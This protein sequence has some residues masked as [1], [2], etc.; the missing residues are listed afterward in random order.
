M[1]SSFS[2]EIPELLN[3]ALAE[4]Q[5]RNPTSDIMESS[6]PFDKYAAIPLH[7]YDCYCI[8]RRG[9]AR[10]VQKLKILE[11]GR[12]MLGRHKIEINGETT[13]TNSLTTF[14]RKTLKMTDKLA[15]DRSTFIIQNNV[16]VRL[17][18]IRKRIWLPPLSDDF[19]EM[20][21][22]PDLIP[23]LPQIV[24]KDKICPVTKSKTKRDNYEGFL[25]FYLRK[26]YVSK[27]NSYENRRK[28]ILN[29]LETCN[30]L[31]EEIEE[32]IQAG[33][34]LLLLKAKERV[35]KRKRDVP[36]SPMQQQQDHGLEEISNTDSPTV[37]TSEISFLSQNYFD[38][39]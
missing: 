39:G 13:Y 14:K 26:L 29:C 9:D 6:F 1:C 31:L 28:R 2:F 22:E 30:H 4:K 17:Q 35:P 8:G 12:P 36:D 21:T 38:N 19:K 23:I 33:C 10:V 34:H 20:E 15:F 7:E 24:V 11:G 16:L 32:E 37:I 5:I 27:I 18:R 25:R 3:N